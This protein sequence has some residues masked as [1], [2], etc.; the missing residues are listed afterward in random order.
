MTPIYEYEC[1]ACGGE[2]E[3]I[4]RAGE[5][6]LRKCPA[7]GALKLRRKVSRSAFHLKGAGWYATGG[8]GSN[9]GAKKG[10]S[11]GGE[12]SG[13]KKAEKTEAKA[14]S[15]PEAK[16][17]TKSEAKTEAKPAAAPKKD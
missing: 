15:K 17:E 1:R 10:D 3:K 9:G 8:Y 16:S 12:G 14:E 2:T 4:Q 13:E 11:E 7:C 5:K 6:P